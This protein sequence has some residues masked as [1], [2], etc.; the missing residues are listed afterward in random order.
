MKNILV[1]NDD[2]ITAH[3]II[4]LAKAASRFGKVT[5]VAPEDQRSAMSHRIT[6]R[7]PI[8]VRKVDFPVEGVTAYATNGTPGDCVRFG[9]LNFMK[10]GADAVISGINCGYNCGTDI[11]YSATAGAALEAASTG[12]HAIAV[13]EGFE[14]CHDVTDTYLEQILEDLLERP[15]GYNQIWNVNFPPCKLEEFQGILEDRTVAKNSFFIDRY[16]EEVLK[17]GT[18]SLTVDGTYHQNAAP[19]TDFRA[20][21]DNYI[22]IGV[23]NNLR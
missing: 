23:V 7:E 3:G 14:D 9:L 21:V 10:E 17:D 4:R 13:S 2:G 5:V 8:L 22:S 20:V 11:Q 16:K 12:V 6:L 19:G 18:I 15:L 1:T